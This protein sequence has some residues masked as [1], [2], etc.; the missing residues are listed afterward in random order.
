MD[1]GTTGARFSAAR[2][3]EIGLVHAVGEEAELDRIVAKYV[4]DLLTS[5]PHA[6]STAKRL[7][8]AVA[9]HA[10]EDVIDHTVET[11]AHQRVSPEGQDGLRAFLE[12]RKPSWTEGL[13]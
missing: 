12:K 5:G 4:N 11:I 9:N 13:E 1:A 7:I 6:V 2:A 10:P 3:K 8:A